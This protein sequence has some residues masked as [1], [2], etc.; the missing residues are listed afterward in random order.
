MDLRLGRRAVL[1]SAGALAACAGDGAAMGEMDAA[2]ALEMTRRPEHYV[3]G[4][5]RAFAVSRD[6][7]AAGLLWGTWHTGYDGATVMPRPIRQR[8]SAASSV[9]VEVVLDRIAPPVRRAMA[10]VAGGALLRADPAAVKRLDLET[11]REL[12]AVGLPSGSLERFSLIGLARLVDQ[13]AALAPVGVLPTIGFVDANLIG[14]ARSVD[15]PVRGLEDAN[16][17]MV[18]RLLYADPNGEGAAAAL[19]LALRRRP[20][21]TALVAWLRRRYAAGEVGAMLAGLVAWR[22]EAADLARNDR[23][24]TGL[25]A[26]R[27]AAW[28]PRL[29]TTLAEPGVAFVAF[30][31]AHLTGADGVVALLRA[32]GW[33][34][35]GCVGDRCVG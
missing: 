27:N 23:G 14:F 22:A 18:E 30:G 16:A 12:D 28:M 26:E 7:R 19:R 17:A 20:Q 11:R 4:E 21:N 33:E 13:R 35:S 3:N 31:A 2:A 15:I 9:S 1:C 32:R 24:R 25:L 8:F 29:E 10:A 34:I 5:A 6:G